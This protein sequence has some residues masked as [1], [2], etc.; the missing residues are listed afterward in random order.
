MQLEGRDRDLVATHMGHNLAVHDAHY[1]MPINTLEVSKV[2]KVLL[3]LESKGGP[4]GL[5]GKSFDSLELP[6]PDSTDLFPST[7]S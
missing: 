4:R 7:G 5:I 6:P 1:R 2:G 3:N